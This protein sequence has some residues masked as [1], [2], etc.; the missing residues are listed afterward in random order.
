MSKKHRERCEIANDVSNRE[1]VSGA[2]FYS[3]IYRDACHPKG[4]QPE[5][6]WLVRTGGCSSE[7][8]HLSGRQGV[9][10]S[11]LTIS[12]VAKPEGKAIK[13]MFRLCGTRRFRASETC[14]LKTA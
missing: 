10:S 13:S 8:E 11:N 7:G 14:S 12:T 6:R 1:S 9:M 2:I 3:F 5:K 4:D